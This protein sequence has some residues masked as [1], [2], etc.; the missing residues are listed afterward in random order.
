MVLNRNLSIKKPD[1]Y[2]DCMCACGKLKIVAAAHLRSGHTT[3]CGCNKLEFLDLTGNIYGRLTVIKQDE[4]RHVLGKTRY[5]WCCCECGKIK[6]I[7]GSS[8]KSGKILSCGC[9]KN[10]HGKYKT[11]EYHTWGNMLDRCININSLLYKSYGGRGIKVCNR[12]KGK[13]GF[14]NFLEDLGKKPSSKHQLDRIDNDGNYEPKNCR[15][16]TPKENTRNK[17][18][19]KYITYNNNTNCVSAWAEGLGISTSTLFGRLRNGWSIERALTQKVQKRTNKGEL[20]DY[21]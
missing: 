5:W 17:R 15:W 20:N 16:V 13:K 7:N 11:T 18:N 21:T 4:D 8:L 10:K 12:W 9:L 1:V 19:T 2:Y 6:S 14:I 3:S